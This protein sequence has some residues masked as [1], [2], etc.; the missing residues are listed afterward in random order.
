M[1][2]CNCQQSYLPYSAFEMCHL[3]NKICHERADWRL[4]TCH[5][6]RL[7]PPPPA[8]RA[9][10]VALATAIII[11]VAVHLQDVKV[12]VTVSD[13]PVEVKAECLMTGDVQGGTVCEYAYAVCGLS[14]LTSLILSLFLVST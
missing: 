11:I 7:K 8:L 1:L 10:Q 5:C 14:L 13:R 3:G 2:V 4:L 12:D 9:R 6:P